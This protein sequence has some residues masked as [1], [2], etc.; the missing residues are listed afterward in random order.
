MS[1]Q[2]RA[3]Q[4]LLC[5]RLHVEPVNLV[6]ADS[7]V[8]SSEISSV[9]QDIGVDETFTEEHFINDQWETDL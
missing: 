5:E 7:V 4:K 2:K 9:G 6:L 1:K 8:M 3:Y